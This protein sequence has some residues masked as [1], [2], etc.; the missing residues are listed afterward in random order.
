M[1]GTVTLVNKT[2][3]CIW[4]LLREAI[5]KIL[6]TRKKFVTMDGDRY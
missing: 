1:H 6:T 2:V 3:V 5:L 4:K